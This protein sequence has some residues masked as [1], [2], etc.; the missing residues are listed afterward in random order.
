MQ[1][2]LLDRDLLLATGRELGQ[3]PGHAVGDAQLALLDQSHDRR[4][5]RDRL[6]DRGEVE[7]GVH[8]HRA[9]RR[10]LTAQAERLAVDDVPLVRDEDH[11][12]RAGAALDGL[13]HHVV[14]AR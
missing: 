13:V 10:L 14:D 4:R 6:G 12:A 2:Q 5:G 8:G 11:G 7:H 3:E 9:F 1:Q